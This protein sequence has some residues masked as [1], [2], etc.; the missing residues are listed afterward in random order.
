MGRTLRGGVVAAVVAVSQVAAAQQPVAPSD[1]PPPLVP[2]TPEPAPQPQPAMPPPQAAP[3]QQAAPPPATSAPPAAS[4]QPATPAQPEERRGLTQFGVGVAYAGVFPSRGATTRDVSELG[5]LLEVSRTAP[6]SESVDFGF[7]F[8]WGLTAWERFPRWAKAGYDAGKWTTQAYEDVYNWTRKRGEDGSYDPNT[9][10]LRL[11]GSFFAFLVL[12]LG[13]AYSGVAYATAVVAPTTWL[14]TNFT[15][16]YNFGDPK[17]GGDNPYLRG[18]A[19]LMAFVHPEHGTL[20]GALGPTFGGGMRL[21]QFHLGT[22]FTWSPAGLHGEARDGRS[23]IVV[24]GVT[25]GIQ[26]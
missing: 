22:N 13:Y 4:A 5:L 1:P 19:A 2:T 14:E 3:V 17:P 11:M 21:G 26:R 9:H 10:G 16:N 24:G 18:G 8:A 25:L 23:Q 20:A 12:W 6:I 15:A 7:R